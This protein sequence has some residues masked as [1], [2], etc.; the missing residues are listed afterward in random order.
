MK[1]LRFNESSNDWIEDILNIARDEDYYVSLE[2]NRY[3]SMSHCLVVSTTE[4]ILIIDNIIDSKE[5]Q[6]RFYKTIQEIQNRFEHVIDI[7]RFEIFGLK[8]NSFEDD[9]FITRYLTDSKNNFLP[10]YA[11]MTLDL[12]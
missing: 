5:E 8:K 4:N 12:N 7:T 11:R 9:E 1:I 6:D 2:K 10:S 3:T